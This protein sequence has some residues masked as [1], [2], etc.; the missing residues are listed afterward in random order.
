MR[1]TVLCRSP[2]APAHHL[3]VTYNPRECRFPRFPLAIPPAEPPHQPP[4]HLFTQ[5]SPGTETGFTERAQKPPSPPGRLSQIMNFHKSAT[6]Q[7]RPR[8]HT[9]RPTPGRGPY[10][11]TPHPYPFNELA[12]S[13]AIAYASGGRQQPAQPGRRPPPERLSSDQQGPVEQLGVLATL[14]RWR[15]RV[16]IPSGPPDARDAR[17]GQVAQSVRASA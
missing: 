11:H 13:S 5:P 2:P 6:I 1:I 17:H 14:S 15:P 4:G 7:Q 9:T 10:L 8:R 12:P 3:P 16:Q